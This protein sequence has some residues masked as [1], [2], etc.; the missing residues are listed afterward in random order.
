MRRF[1]GLLLTL[2]LSC[3]QQPLELDAP[4]VWLEPFNEGVAILLTNGTLTYVTED[5]TFNASQGWLGESVL[6]CG[7]S[8]FGNLRGRLAQPESDLIGLEIAPHHRSACLN[9]EHLAVLS[10]DAQTLLLFDLSFTEVARTPVN[11]LPDT[12]ITLADVTGDGE[13]EVILLTEPTERYTHGVLGDSL[14]AV[15]ISIFDSATLELITEYTLPEPFVFEQRRVTPFDM[16]GKEGLLATRSSNETGAGVVLLSLENNNLQIKAEA[17][18]IGTGFR[19]LNLFANR[20]GRAYA[21]RTPHIGGPLQRYTLNEDKLEIE[22][23]QLGVTNHTLG[24]RNLDLGLLLPRLEVDID[25]L[26]L[27][28]QGLRTLKLI[29]CEAAG[30]MV[31]NELELGGRLSSNLS[32]VH[33]EKGLQVMAGVG[34]KLIAWSIAP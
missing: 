27:P 24:S 19:W 9:G 29:R 17:Q 33:N 30:C 15:S 20:N 12:E 31:A 13:Q 32:Y 3:A 7:G 5:G 25:H 14:E 4:A 21:V 1:Y 16:D 18:S 28:S 10:Q 8:M 34:S 2:S 22:T 23:F 26:V 11:A 6:A